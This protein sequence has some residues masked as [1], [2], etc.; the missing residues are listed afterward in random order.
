[1]FSKLNYISRSS[2]TPKE[3]IK[4]VKL[5]GRKCVVNCCL[6]GKETKVLWDTGA[7]VAL[8][9][10][11]W[12][13]ENFPEKPIKDVSE[14]LGHELFLKVANNSHLDYLGYVEIVFKM[15]DNAEPLMVP[16]LVTE[17][18]VE[19]PLVGYNVIEEVA[20]HEKDKLALIG[21]IESSMGKSKKKAEALVNLIQKKA[22][23][24]EPD[25]LGGV[26][27]GNKDVVIPKGRNLKLHCVARCGPVN[28]DTAVMFE[29]NLNHD[30]HSGLVIGEGVVTL[31]RGK[32]KLI[33]PVSNPTSS[34]I[35]L[36]SQTQVGVIVPVASVIP[37]PV[38]INSIGRA[39]A[40]EKVG[41]EPVSEDLQTD[42]DD[43]NEDDADGEESAVDEPPDKVTD[44]EAWLSKIDLS[45]LTVSQRK[46]VKEMLIRNAEVF[47][48]DSNDIGEIKDLQMKINLKD[49]EPVKASYTS[50]PKPLYKEVK[51]YV[52]DLLASG[53]VQKSN[54]SYS[55]P[56]VC[57][58]KKDGTLRLCVDYRRLNNKTIPDS[59]PIP[60]V[61][62]I[63]NSLGGNKYFTTL[64]MSK[65]YHQG[66]V[67]EDSRH[68]TAFATPWSL[69]EWVRIPFGLMNAPPVFQRYMNECL[70]GLRDV[71]CIP[72]LDD[73]LVYSKNFKL[74]L[75]HQETVLRRLI[76]HGIKLNPLKCNWFKKAVKYLGHIVSEEGYKADGASD[77]VI[78]KLKVAPTT[79]GE[80]RSLLGFVG[81]YRSFIQDFSRKAKPLYDLL[82]KDKEKDAESKKVGKKGKK[83]F[84]RPSSDKISWEKV[85][86]DIVD[87]LLEILKCP[88]V[89]AYPDFSLPFV[90]HCDASETGL[91]AVLYQEQNEKLRVVSY[92]SRTLTPAEK[93]YY[94]HSGKLE[95]LALKWSVTERF[96]DY[97][98]YAPSFTIYSDCNPL[99]YVMSSAKLNATTM[100]WVGELANYNFS[101]KYRPGKDSTDC[102]Y[103]SRNP[104]DFAKVM[105]QHKEEI[106][107]EMIGA[108]VAG[109]Q[110]KGKF[111]AVN[112][113]APV[114]FSGLG[115]ST[116]SPINPEE[117]KA[118]QLEDETI[119]VVMRMVES[120]KLPSK[121]EKKAL[122]KKQKS[123]LNQW[124]KLEI[125]K[126]GVLI[127]KTT[128]RVQIVLP[129]KFHKLVFEELHEKMGHLSSERVIQLAQERFFWPYLAKDVQH[130][131]Q[132]VCQCLKRK[133]PNRE[134]RAPLVNIHSSEPFELVSVDFLHLDKSKGGYE[135]LL[136][137]VDHFTRFVQVYPT[138][139]KK[140]RTAADKIFNEYIL[141]FGFPKRLH[142]DQG[143][144]FENKLFD[145]LHELAGVEAS[146]T[147][148]Y[149]PQGDGQVERM[150]RTLI[151]MLKTLPEVYKSNWKDHVNKLVFAYNST[152]N[153][154]TTFSPFQ[155]MFGRSPRLPIDFMFNLHQDPDNVSYG[156]YVSSWKKAM[157]E[158]CVIAGKNAK[159]NAGLGKKFHDKKLFGATLSVGDRVLVRNTQKGGTGKLRSH[160]E[161]DVYV[162]S[163][164]KD[165]NIPVFAVKRENGTG[166]E[167]L[168]HRDRLMPCDHLPLETPDV[169]A[170]ETPLPADVPVVVK[171]KAVT[172]KKAGTKKKAVAKD[173]PIDV[174]PSQSVKPSVKKKT[175]KKG[176]SSKIQVPQVV[177][178]SSDSESSDEE[179]LSR[180]R[181]V[182]NN[183]R[184]DLLTFHPIQSGHQISTAVPNVTQHVIPTAV[185]AVSPA[186]APAVPDAAQPVVAVAAA[187][188]VVVPE[189]VDAEETVPF[190]ESVGDYEGIQVELAPVA[191]ADIEGPDM[192]DSTITD[193]V[194]AAESTLL[195]DV[196]V[197]ADLESVES[198]DF[199]DA[200]DVTPV[201]TSDV[202]VEQ[203]PVEE[204]EETVVYDATHDIWNPEASAA[205]ESTAEA[206]AAEATGAEASA[207]DVTESGAT[208]SSAAS[209][210]EGE[211]EDIDTSDL[212][213]RERSRRRRIT[214][215]RLTY[216]SMGKQSDRRNR[217]LR[218]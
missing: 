151:N 180:C 159:K 210:G 130:Y 7:E 4:L 21:M 136:V 30:L 69:L 60:K 177:A 143:G 206:T 107:S 28:G 128:H 138:R 216:Y 162:V 203:N 166:N 186:A 115:N 205:D 54:S 38:D 215:N 124:K 79:V 16:F 26:K 24:D 145:R 5:V 193:I 217:F 213:R 44:H 97:L 15:S 176:E 70:V 101:V 50:I 184:D 118:A 111:A 182:L 123:L 23:C 56:M 58:R 169:D 195:G 212:N 19:I 9:S 218:K 198:E 74:H 139:N 131:V 167:R 126:D 179:W 88:P 190:D 32:L 202:V 37:C 194:P 129:V 91:G 49:D 80:L 108:V 104:V 102:D 158:A 100:R 127:R 45:H 76:E 82:C 73:V 18:E 152:K 181:Y 47:S 29:P 208:D 155:L 161:E 209:L 92:A 121:E 77:E 154:S 87:E 75:K 10:R 174:P 35:V 61:Q 168:L 20:K 201:N 51:E 197:D 95:F 17:E 165:D 160:W 65:A 99:S 146:R 68:L 89:I 137:L 71:I 187:P 183:C 41:A 62:D 96:N 85:H 8:I 110:S 141:R 31:E 185:P 132:N 109:S 43:D 178:V 98:Y 12:L 52:E 84:Q 83:N 157:Q 189:H 133:K 119:G 106:S 134:Q 72:Y 103:L 112:S 94:L 66:F 191:D 27:T 172:K 204:D 163:G 14:L 90:L 78:D 48:T 192:N 207:A 156:Q 164:R 148:P 33:I 53:W 171:K 188:E 196:N 93:N 122:E 81:Y 39:A 199:V 200:L 147:T 11:T 34:D 25:C 86:Q 40:V 59:Q 105:D 117:V 153:S 46:Q 55:S 42:V 142:H 3:E 1:M 114:M 6:E 116:M 113:V 57:V 144:E 140:G 175:K 63:L 36:K 22:N 125:N 2:L 214:P 13:D 173:A 64:D 150:N 120:G 149:H 170:V 211:D 67:H 135:Y